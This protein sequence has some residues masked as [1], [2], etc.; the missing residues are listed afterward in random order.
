MPFQVLVIDD[1]KDMLVLLDRI[2]SEDPELAVTVTDDSRKVQEIL[3]RAPVDL[4]LTDL[5]M[6]HVD[7]LEVLEQVKSRSPMTAVVIMT[8]YGTIDSAIE[9][10]RKGAFDYVTKPF[11]KERIL[12]VAEQSLRWQRLQMENRLLREQLQDRPR[13]PALIGKSPAM[14]ELQD[15]IVQVARTAATVLLTGESGTGKEL[16]ARAIH[17]HSQ[18]SSKPFVPVNCSTIPENLVESELFGHVRGSFTGALRDKKGL[19]EEADQ[20]SLFLDE[21]GDLSPALQ[22][23]LLRLLQEGEFKIVGDN[24]IR[25]VDVRFVAATH[26][27]LQNG[28]RSGTFREDL[29]YRLNVINIHLPPLRERVSDIPLLAHHFLRKYTVLHGK[30]Q[31]H[32]LSR[33]A[34]ERLLS[35]EWPGNIRELE[36]AIE[37]GVIMAQAELIGECDLGITG[38]AHGRIEPAGPAEGMFALPYKDARDKL[39][40]DFQASYLSRLLAKHEGNVSRA[41]QDSGVKRQY[42]HRLMRDVGL[43]SKNFRK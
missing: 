7:G 21:I 43:E 13:F 4:V 19:V 17:S 35:W 3:E 41:A 30:N 39:L 33:D 29:Y 25:S 5:K 34:M 22:I 23:K 16:V 9:A 15:K 31:V 40:E 6:P 27:D 42:L 11:R 32:G 8:A 18:R 14:E 26:K 28:I 2:L 36:N 20:G 12:Q 24:R 10:T 38:P 1:E 37:R